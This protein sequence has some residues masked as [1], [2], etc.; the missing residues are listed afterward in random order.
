MQIEKGLE[1]YDEN[2]CL[3]R[4]AF[5]SKLLP[6]D[7]MRVLFPASSLQALAAG[8]SVDVVRQAI[9]HSSQVAARLATAKL[10]SPA[11]TPA[12]AAARGATLVGGPNTPSTAMEPAC[13]VSSGGPSISRQE[14]SVRGGQQ[15]G[16]LAAAAPSAVSGSK[17][18]SSKSRTGAKGAVAAAAGAESAPP[19]FTTTGGHGGGGSGGG[20]STSAKM[21]VIP[22]AS[23]EPS[24]GSS[25]SSG[26]TGGGRSYEPGYPAAA[27]AA[28]S[29]HPST[30]APPTG[31]KPSASGAAPTSGGS[32]SSAAKKQHRRGGLSMFL[33]G[34]AAELPSA[35]GPASA[36]SRSRWC[37]GDNA[38]G[39]QRSS[40]GWRQAAVRPC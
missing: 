4:L 1:S 24:G 18:Y 11:S 9:A 14:G 33:S 38:G 5:F 31:L 2:E 29:P 13:S 36:S 8:A 34:P 10:D 7:Q 22:A 16:N 35:A 12:A 23:G 17:S 20:T 19:P 28:A 26:L 25:S 3:N 32:S 30:P 27:T 37:C 6:E 21:A 40:M 15:E 39:F